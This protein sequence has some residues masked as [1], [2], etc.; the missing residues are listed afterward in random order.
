MR[1]HISATS[2]QTL[3]HNFSLNAIK[4]EADEAKKQLEAAGPKVT[5]I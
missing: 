2:S 5:I 4:D 3:L 1:F